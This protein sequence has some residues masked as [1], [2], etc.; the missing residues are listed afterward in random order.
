MKISFRAGSALRRVGLVAVLAA[1]VVAT[2]A[3]VV[4]DPFGIGGSTSGWRA[5]DY[6]HT[7]CHGAGL[8]AALFDNVDGRMANLDVQTTFSDSL[9]GCSG[10]T[11][12]TFLD[13]N[14]ATGYRGLY[15]C[16][17]LRVSTCWAS[18]VTLDPAEINLG[19]NDEHDT[20]KTACHEIGHSVGLTHGGT[21][22]CM[23][24][25]EAPSPPATAN[26]QY[27][28]HHVGHINSQS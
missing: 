17:D 13:G 21:T 1:V 27:D 2:P 4:A 28:A 22:D 9:I 3:P 19:A 12:V 24:S 16:N 18:T 25:G 20:S 15:V 14:L 8:D 10:V 26:V 7:F 5:D 23:R 11:D 6:N